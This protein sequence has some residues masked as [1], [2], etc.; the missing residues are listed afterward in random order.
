MGD[1]NTARTGAGGWPVSDEIRIP[2]VDASWLV[3]VL[4]VLPG[5]AVL[6][7][8]LEMPPWCEDGR[9]YFQPSA[10]PVVYRS[11]VRYVRHPQH[12]EGHYEPTGYYPHAV[13]DVRDDWTR[14]TLE[15]MVERDPYGQ[16]ALRWWV[17]Q[18]VRHGD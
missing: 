9:F 2:A 1:E 16:R 7:P 13:P 14:A 5:M 17:G 18:V 12:G 3:G 6:V 15:R 8:V 10:R 4:P 11:G